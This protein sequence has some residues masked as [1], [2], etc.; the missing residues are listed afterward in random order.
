MKLF[1]EGKIGLGQASAP[2]GYSKRAFEGILE[3]HKIPVSDYP[4]EEP[5]KDLK[6]ALGC[7][8]VKST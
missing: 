8:V 6:N 3:K 2:A 7:Y 5:K 1:K 4:T